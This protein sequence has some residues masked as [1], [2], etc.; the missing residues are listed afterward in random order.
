MK[1]LLESFIK[2]PRLPKFL[3]A[4]LFIALPLSG[5]Y[6]GQNSQKFQRKADQGEEIK[7]LRQELEQKEEEVNLC[8]QDSAKVIRTFTEPYLFT[9]FGIYS[10]LFAGKQTNNTVYV[11]KRK[12]VTEKNI[13]VLEDDNKNPLL[14]ATVWEFT[15]STGTTLDSKE[16]Y[17]IFG[18]YENYLNRPTYVS[19]LQKNWKEAYVNT[20]GIKMF[21][22][23]EWVPKVIGGVQL[24]FYHQ[25]SPSGHPILV[26][27]RYG[28]LFAQTVSDPSVARA[29]EKLKEFADTVD[30]KLG[31]SSSE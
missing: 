10:P 25:S 11:F 13:T 27:L 16:S 19:D 26:D 4:I 8:I 22:L 18:G 3:V 29:R 1:I 17:V 23:Y 30:V 6:L 31:E 5:F 20:K 12:T 21:W 2:N 7:T 15:S 24:M 14:I 9:K 28:G